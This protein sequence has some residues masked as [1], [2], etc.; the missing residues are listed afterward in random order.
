[1]KTRLRK[2]FPFILFV[3][4]IL[5][6]CEENELSTGL[7]GT[8]FRGPINPVAIE[9]QLNDEPFSAEF[10]VYDHLDNFIISF[11]SDDEGKF[12]VAMPPGV[13]LVIPDESAPI[14]NP[15]HQIKEVIVYPDSLTSLDLYFDT[16]IR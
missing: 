9:G 12:S 3:I 1:M 16:G 13:Y 14:M 8:A 11:N 15:E 4:L 2:F 5:A 10:N 7:A 6:A